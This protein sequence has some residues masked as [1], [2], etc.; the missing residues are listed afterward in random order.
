VCKG[1]VPVQLSELSLKR[2]SVVLKCDYDGRGNVYW[3]HYTP[4]RS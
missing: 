2:T 3:V 1:E 4:R